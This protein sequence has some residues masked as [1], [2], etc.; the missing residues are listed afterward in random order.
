[1]IV[2]NGIVERNFNFNFKTVITVGNFDGV[3]AGHRF[4][5]K[6]TGELAKKLNAKSLVFSFWPNTKKILFDNK[7]KSIFDRYERRLILKNLAIDYLFEFDFDYEKKNIRSRD[8]L[9]MLIKKFN[10]VGLV[11]GEDFKFG[12]DDSKK[13]LCEYKSLNV[14]VTKKKLNVSS[15]K[16]RNLILDRKFGAV[17]KLMCE[18]YFVYKK[19]VRMVG[20][21]IIFF[22]D[23]NK[24][25]PPDGIYKTKVLID[26]KIFYAVAEIIEKRKIC[27]EVFCCDLDKKIEFVK[28]IF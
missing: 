10:C 12:C 18:N 5:L 14:I 7:F 3:H 25:L 11:L 27:C 4:L 19:N 17:K 2:L 13:I 8:F 23:E 26:G 28:V 22:A 1:M 6:K 24:L 16:I 15:S 21:K 20:R 9:E